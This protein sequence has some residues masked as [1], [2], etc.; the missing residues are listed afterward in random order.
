MKLEVVKD[1]VVERVIRLV[2]DV[3]E[4]V[5]VLKMVE[6]VYFDVVFFCNVRVEEV[7]VLYDVEIK[8]VSVVVCVVNEVMESVYEDVCVVV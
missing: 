6:G 8:M 5:E 2:L 4:L 1:E 7:K 3:N